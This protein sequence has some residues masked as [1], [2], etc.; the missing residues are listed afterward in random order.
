MS[1]NSYGLRASMAVACLVGL[2]MTAA[3]AATTSHAMTVAGLAQGGIGVFGC[4]TSG[5]Q[6]A[7]RGFFS[8]GVGLPTEGYGVCNLKGDIADNSAPGATSAASSVSASFNNGVANVAATAVADYDHIGTEA[9]GDF[10]G[11]TNAASY[12]ASEAAAFVYDT[13]NFA[14]TGY[15]TVTLGFTIDG[16]LSAVGN[17]EA[18]T[19]LA[20]QLG[21]GP[22]YSAFGA[23]AGYG[24]NFVTGLGDISGFIGTG[25]SVSGS[26]FVTTFDL[27]I[28]FGQTYDWTT[29]LYSAAYPGSFI[30]TAASSFLNTAKLTSIVVKDAAGQTIDTSIL[31]GSGTLYDE[32][33]AHV[34]AA[35]AVPE[36][37]TWAMMIVGFGTIGASMRRRRLAIRF[38]A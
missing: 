19:Q 26:A 36:P 7:I 29:G 8:Q 25:A 21:D 38:A 3:E 6:A 23:R 24:T 10:T 22:I 35:A 9:Q 31:S 32:N 28:V 5:P 30:G 13:L 2:G 12:H 17:S 4:A 1:R 16:A 37:A 33:G 20:Y 34:E 18:F 27:P 14:G 11:Y 15:G